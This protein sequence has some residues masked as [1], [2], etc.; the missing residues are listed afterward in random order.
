MDLIATDIADIGIIE[1]LWQKLHEH[2]S[3]LH[4][5][6]FGREL[7]ETWTRKNREFVARAQECRTKF[8]V[9]KSDDWVVGYCV[10]AIN[11]YGQGEIV[12]I[13]VLPE[14]RGKGI[15]TRLMDEHLRWL[16]E[17]QVT[18]IFLFVHPCNIDAIRF[19]WRF[20]FFASGPLME[21]CK[22]KDS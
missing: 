21:L 10:S 13:Y 15:G 1:P 22:V 16:R 11:K 18:S 6:Y 2:N 9:V 5:K 7:K 8:H 17:N 12:S 20:S 3:A 19:Y 14:F 4:K